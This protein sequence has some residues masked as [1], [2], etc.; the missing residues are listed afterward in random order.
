MS[1][2]FTGPAGIYSP[3]VWLPLVDLAAFG[4]SAKL[5][6]RDWPDSHGERGARFRMLREGNSELRGLATGAAI[7][8]GLIGLV[9]LLAC[10][11]VANQRRREFGVRVAVGATPR[12][13]IA[14]VLRS[15][16]R[17]LVPGLIAGVML[18]AGLARLAQAAFIG[19]NVLNPLSYLAVALLQCAIV[20][21][22][23]LAPALRAS[24]VDPLAALRAE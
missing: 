5:Q 2:D 4:T 15:A 19:V 22:A 23:C 17:L 12:D 21:L 18:A 16:G 6:A 10:F 13:L 1:G 24:R 9:L 3:D 20:V 11:N 7:G 14:D 8:M